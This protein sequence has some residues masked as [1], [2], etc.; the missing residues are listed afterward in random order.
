MLIFI[1]RG[2]E[3]VNDFGRDRSVGALESGWRVAN[4]PDI[5]TQT[6]FLSH[7]FLIEADRSLQCSS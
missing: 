5:K 2:S 6:L 7:I 4:A 3:M 1:R